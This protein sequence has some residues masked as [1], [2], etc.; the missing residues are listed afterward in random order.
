MSED[1]NEPGPVTTWEG[2]PADRRAEGTHKGT[3]VFAWNHR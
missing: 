3:A 2:V 1:D